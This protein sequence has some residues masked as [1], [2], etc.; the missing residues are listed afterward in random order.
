ME[1]T[2]DL[3]FQARAKMAENKV[4]GQK[5]SVVSEMIKQLPQEII[6][7]IT[8]CFQERLMGWRMH[9]APGGS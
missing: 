7:E 2:I 8:R 6:H 4:N 5:D 3:V 1:I 9:P